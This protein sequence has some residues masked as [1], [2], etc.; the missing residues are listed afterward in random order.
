MTL[1]GWMCDWSWEIG[2][3]IGIVSAF[4]SF[5]M[6]LLFS[7]SEPTGGSFMALGL[8]PGVVFDLFINDRLFPSFESCFDFECDVG[9][10]CD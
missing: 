4:G 5:F 8:I 1:P 3:W 6:L 10:D 7:V 2:W 9:F